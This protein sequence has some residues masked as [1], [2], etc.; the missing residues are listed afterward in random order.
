MKKIVLLSCAAILMFSMSAKSQF[1]STFAGSGVAGFA[2]DSG[3]AVSA[4]LF[5]PGGLAIDKAGNTYIID[6]QNNR[7][8]KVFS[9]GIIV[10]I[11]GN[12]ISGYNGDSILAVNAELHQPEGIAVDAIGNV[13]IADELNN[14]IRKIDTNGYITT[15]AGTG[16]IGFTGDNGPAKAAKLSG[17]TGVCVDNQGNILIA[18][19]S[20]SR[21]RKIDTNGIIT[22]VAGSGVFGYDGDNWPSATMAGLRDP[23]S[24]AVDNIGNI[25][26]VDQGDQRIRKVD[27]FN[28][29]STIYGNGLMG[30]SGDGLLGT[31]S[32]MYYPTSVAVDRFGNVYVCDEQNYRIRKLDHTFKTVKTI[33]GNGVSGFV[34]DTGYAVQNEIGD[35]KGVAVDSNG[36]VYFSDW[37]N[38]RVEYVT[39]VVSVNNITGNISEVN[40]YPNPNE[41]AFTVNISA[42]NNEEVHLVVTNIIGQEIKQATTGTNKPVLI[43]LDAPPGIYFITATTSTGTWSGR[44]EVRSR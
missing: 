17:P 36:N 29:I 3:M 24:V 16:A 15:I 41:G 39:S 26:V 34:G 6:L 25:Y 30:Y 23:T 4:K 38:N 37:S 11:A 14:R 18:D 7:I 10:T 22:T 31:N 27:T 43:N 12:G 35:P 44:V 5:G 13:Y 8:R 32:R 28:K 9:F 1:I 2:G 20:N 21:I 42:S 19:R 40:I 33:A